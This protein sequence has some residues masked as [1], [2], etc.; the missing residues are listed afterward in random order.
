MAKISLQTV[1]RVHIQEEVP[2]MQFYRTRVCILVNRYVPVLKDTICKRKMVIGCYRY[3]F[4]KKTV[5]YPSHG[6]HAEDWYDM[7]S[8]GP[9]RSY[10]PDEN[11]DNPFKA[12][13]PS[14]LR[15]LWDDPRAVKID[16]AH[17]YA[18][19]GWGKDC[20]ASDI[21]FLA[22]RCGVFEAPDRFQEQLHQAWASFKT[23][24]VQNKKCTSIQDFAKEDLKITSSLKRI[25]FI[26]FCFHL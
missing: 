20:A 5:S 22:V 7:T 26:A 23:W 19:A 1:H 25:Y 9:M 10:Q 18:I 16:L 21:V 12:G 15:L 24:C 4:L 17:T 8:S 14:P 6:N 13:T 2:P 11:I 3:L